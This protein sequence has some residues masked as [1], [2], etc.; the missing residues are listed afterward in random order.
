[1]WIL[2]GV[3]CPDDSL[4]CSKNG[5]CDVNLVNTQLVYSC[6]CK[7]GYRGNGTACNGKYSFF[8]YI[9]FLL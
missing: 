6:R 2:E 9:F 1:M 8:F 4:I 3:P 5:Q 7:D